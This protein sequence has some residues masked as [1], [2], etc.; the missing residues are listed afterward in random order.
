M[1]LAENSTSAEVQLLDVRGVAR[2]LG[3]SVRHVY[4]MSDAGRMPRP[5]KLGQLVRCRRAAIDK[6]VQDGCP[7]CRKGGKR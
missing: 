7:P 1:G 2:Q 3:C 4:R 5:L 6:W